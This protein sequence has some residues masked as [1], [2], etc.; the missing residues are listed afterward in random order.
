MTLQEEKEELAN[1]P[2]TDGGAAVEENEQKIGAMQAQ[3]NAITERIRDD[4]RG[5][6][7]TGEEGV[8]AAAAKITSLVAAAEA[9]AAEKIQALHYGG[10]PKG[11]N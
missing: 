3:L 8:A 5:P 2:V 1:K 10:R 6:S 9:D 11:K 4:G 7:T